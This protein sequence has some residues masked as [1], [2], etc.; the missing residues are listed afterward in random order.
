MSIALEALPQ[1][2][3]HAL[4]LLRE[5]MQAAGCVFDFAV[6]GVLADA[7]VELAHH[8]A[9][10]RAMFDDIDAQWALHRQALRAQGMDLPE[11][12][13]AAMQHELARASATPWD[14]RSVCDAS[15]F[16]P[17]RSEGIS[18]PAPPTTP[19]E[20]LFRAFDDPPYG[21]R[22]QPGLFA[23]FCQ[24]VG[25]LPA[26]DIVVFDWV[27][28]PEQA[29][30]RSAWSAYFDDGKEWWGIWCLTVWNP[31]Q[32]TIAALAASATD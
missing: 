10:L 19:F 6:R 14:A 25:L 21:T 20:S 27:G 4:A 2:R 32:R 28:D 18:F 1:E 7:G 24:A 17:R 16:K 22:A 11:P 15:G 9:V 31:R 13:P 3:A 26:Q 5:R 12:L 23:D 30:Q 29:P 8:R